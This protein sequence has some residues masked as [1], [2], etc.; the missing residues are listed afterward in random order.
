MLNRAFFSLQSPWIPTW[1]A[2]GNLGLNAALDGAFYRVGIWGMP[3]STSI[4]NIAGTVALLYLLRREAR[5]DRRCRRPRRTVL[6]V[7]IASGALAGVS[8]G[9]WAG[10]ARRA[11]RL[12]RRRARRAVARARAAGS[13]RTSSRAVCSASASSRRSLS[14]RRPRCVTCSLRRIDEQGRRD[15]SRHDGRDPRHDRG[16]VPAGDGG[17][18]LGRRTTLLRASSRTTRARCRTACSS[19]TSGRAPRTGRTSREGRLGAAIAQ[20]AG[21]EGP[22][23]EPRFFPLIRE[24]HEL[25]RVPAAREDDLR[26]SRRGSAASTSRAGGETTIDES[27]AEY[28][29]AIEGR[30]PTDHYLIVVDGR[31]DRDDPDLPRLRLPR[32]GGDRPGRRGRRRRRP[33]DRRGGLIG[34]GLGPQILARFAREVVTASAV[35]ATVEEENRRS[36]RAFEK[37]GFRHVRDVEE[38]GMP[39]RLMR[40]DR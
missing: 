9:I 6:L 29:A 18:E 30:E 40:L 17:D 10:L 22:R 16:H 31:R 15:G 23:P 3:L 1:V 37:A 38:D 34:R 20:V 27:L 19:S 13:G 12:V 4:V 11:R 33:S 5:P 35:V 21:G 32:V 24:E 28:R 2:L 14:L 36:W 7:T 39:H 25:D 26:S 8:Y